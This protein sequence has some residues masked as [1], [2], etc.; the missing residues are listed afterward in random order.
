M[1]RAEI[2]RLRAEVRSDRAAFVARVTE[3]GTLELVTGGAPAMAQAAV[4]LH[5]A[6]G[7]IEA[8][9]ARVARLLEGSLPQG[10]DWHQQL[11]VTMALEIPTVRPAVLSAESSIGLRKLLAFR[12]FF[13]HAYSVDWDG[14]QLASLCDTALQLRAPLDRDLDAL[15]VFLAQLAA[16]VGS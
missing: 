2:E 3:L 12:H 6:F 8:A 5:H 9:L 14:E 7:A 13:R 10:S 11:L 16:A 4:A 15:D 1:T